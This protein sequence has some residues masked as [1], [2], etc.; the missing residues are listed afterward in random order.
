MDLLSNRTKSKKNG[1]GVSCLSKLYSIIVP[2][3][4]CEDE[5][6]KCIDSILA[7]T[8]QH[9]ELIL[10]NDGSS[11][12]SGKICDLYAG[13]DD[14]IYVIHKENSGVSSARNAGLDKAKGEYIVFIDA[15]DYVSN[16]LLETFERS[17]EDLV[18]VGYDVL[19]ESREKAN[20]FAE[21][22]EIIR[23]ESGSDIVHFL[24]KLSSMYVWGKRYLRR[25]IHDNHLAFDVEQKRDEDGLFNA[26]YI[27]FTE[28]ISYREKIGYHYCR[29]ERE[30]L[31]NINEHEF[32]C[33]YLG[34]KKMID[35]FI[36]YPEVQAYLANRCVFIAE[37]EIN[38]VTSL[39]CPYKE[40]VKLIKDILG[41]DAFKS[42]LEKAS[43]ELID[44]KRRF[45]YKNAL[46]NLVLFRYTIAKTTR[47]IRA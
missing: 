11:D 32:A 39:S 28:S 2:V 31:S 21:K 30:T 37:K 43:P 38:R 18:V 34:R 42:C 25:I 46:C 20:T 36:A 16:Q 27:L 3:Y 40:K 4:N 12:E 41:S 47:K 5:L 9:F 6:G 17:T 45:A 13:K 33:N 35:L 26:Y 7:Q 23:I 19:D 29:H 15:D 10:V 44:E 1:V 24:S 22:A 14:R 8:Y